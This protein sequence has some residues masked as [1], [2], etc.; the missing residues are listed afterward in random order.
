MRLNPIFILAVCLVFHTMPVDAGQSALRSLSPRER[1]G[2]R[3]YLRGE[4]NSGNPI[5]AWLGNPP[6]KVSAKMLPCMNCHGLDGRGKP[7]G[8]VYPSNLNWSMLTKRY[9]LTHPSGRKHRAYDEE[10]LKRAITRGIDPSGNKLGS[11]MPQFSMS[12]DD[13]SSLVAYLKR[14][15]DDRDPGVEDTNITLATVLPLSGPVG[16]LGHAVKEV[17]EAVFDDMNASGGIYNRKI[18]L[19]IIQAGRTPAES[20]DQLRHVLDN[21]GIFALVAPY[22]PEAE[23]QLIELAEEREIPVIGSLGTPPDG[24][25]S[26][27]RYIFYLLSG[28]SVQTRARVDSILVESE[29]AGPPRAGLLVRSGAPYTSLARTIEDQCRRRQIPLTLLPAYSP[30]TFSPEP[31]A[32]EIG[33]QDVLFFI[34]PAT[35]CL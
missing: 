9:G 27:I 12:K 16:R 11:S 30:L 23:D 22:V 18:D 33:Q 5:H 17:L 7:E 20:I 31:L 13:L 21:E 3:I 14:I 4:S 26:S 32:E 29:R 1:E 10:T 15:E 8:G 6:M 2:K 24:V 19:R 34:G 25:N 35:D 28:V